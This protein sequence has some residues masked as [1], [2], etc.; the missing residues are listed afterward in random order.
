[1]TSERLFVGQGSII[2]IPVEYLHRLGGDYISAALLSQIV[3][4]DNW[5]RKNGRDGWFYKSYDDW[6]KDLVIGSQNTISRAKCKLQSLGIIEVE[7]KKD[8]NGTPK[9]HWRINEY[10][11]D[12]WSSAESTLQNVQSPLIQNCKDDF[13]ETAESSITETTNIDYL[14]SENETKPKKQKIQNNND[15]NKP[16]GIDSDD[17]TIKAKA[18]EE[19]I[20]YVYHALATH[21]PANEERRPS[22]KSAESIASAMILYY[23]RNGNDWRY[24]H[25]NKLVK[26][27]KKCV[28]T[29]V[30]NAIK[31]N[32]IEFEEVFIPFSQRVAKRSGE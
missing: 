31:R 10:A 9:N 15:G 20:G 3:Y 17:P 25:D 22:R 26:S 4:W 8:S 12:K 29:F 2:P 5:S 1:M 16:L 13:A 30:Q 21:F 7:T 28:A 24:G 23:S 19:L 14:H 6:M 11:Y 18:R 27:W 32:E